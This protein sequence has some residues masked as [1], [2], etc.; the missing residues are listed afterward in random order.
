[1]ALEIRVRCDTLSVGFSL[2]EIISAS[3][4]PEALAVDH[5]AGNLISRRLRETSFTV[6]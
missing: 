5:H 6:R 3:R 2:N 1:M 4:L